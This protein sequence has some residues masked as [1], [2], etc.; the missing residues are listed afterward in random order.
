MGVEKPKK[1]RI[2]AASAK[3]KGRLCQQ[4]VRD[5]ILVAFPKLTERD[6]KSTSMGASGVDVQ[7]SEAAVKVFPYAVETKNCEKLSIWAAFKQAESNRTKDTDPLLVIKRNREEPL[8]I[9]R[10]TDFMKIFKG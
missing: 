7:L 1:K 4:M 9:L 3:Q 10:F 6:V 5:A 8:V 2:S